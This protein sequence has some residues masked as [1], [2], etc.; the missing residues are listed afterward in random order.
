MGRL[1]LVPKSNEL[2][3]VPLAD[4]ASTA[5]HQDLGCGVKVVCGPFTIVIAA[6]FDGAVLE[7]VLRAVGR[8]TC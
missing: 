3:F 5:V 8:H 6:D 1:R 2:K 4:V 7:S